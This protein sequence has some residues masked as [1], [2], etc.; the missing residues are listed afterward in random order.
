MSHANPV[1]S[2]QYDIDGWPFDSL[3]RVKSAV[4]HVSTIQPF[5]INVQ[6]GRGAIALV[7]INECPN[8]PHIYH[9]LNMPPWWSTVW[10]FGNDEVKRG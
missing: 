3:E 1:L 7:H 6:Y 4:S 9:L 2:T 10:K 8:H 5:Q